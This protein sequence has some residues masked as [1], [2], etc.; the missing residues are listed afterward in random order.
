MLALAIAM[1]L[2]PF[3]LMV[4]LPLAHLQRLADVLCV[5]MAALSLWEVLP[6]VVKVS[7]SVVV[8]G[9]ATIFAVGSMIKL[10]AVG[11]VTGVL[12][13]TSRSCLLLYFSGLTSLLMA[14]DLFTLSEI[15][16]FPSQ[17]AGKNLASI[18]GICFAVGNI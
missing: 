2:L 3:V 12:L 18:F 15:V 6:P 8:F 13:M 5:L 17:I 10:D 11:V 4:L 1:V 14:L 9:V 7:V 16:S